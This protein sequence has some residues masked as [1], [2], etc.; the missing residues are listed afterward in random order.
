V[1]A[2]DCGLHAAVIG[3]GIGGLATAL[4]LHE[5]G[6]QVDVFDSTPELRPLGVGINLLPHAARELDA[7]GLLDKLRALGITPS[8]LVYCT[9][10][11]QEIWREPRGVAAGYPWPQLSVHR[12]ILQEVLRRAVVERLGAD[13]LHLGRRLVR[14]AGS[15]ERPVAEFADGEFEADFI[16]AADG[17]HSAVRAQRYPEA[18]VRRLSHR[19]SAGRAAALQFHRGAETT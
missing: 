9:K 5:V 17:I 18:E 7:L 3:A 16:V 14:V 11:G 4:S 15:D 19:R 13:A 1:N 10:R 8:V 12:G 2:T 6:V